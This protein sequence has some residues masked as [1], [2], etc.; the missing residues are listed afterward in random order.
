MNQVLFVV[1]GVDDSPVAGGLLESDEALNAAAVAL[2]QD[3]V[4]V[5]PVFD[6]VCQV[7]S[8]PLMVTCRAS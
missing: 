2:E 7:S 3:G 4:V 1:V 8:V 6:V 5:G